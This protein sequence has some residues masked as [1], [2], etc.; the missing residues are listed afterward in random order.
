MSL[1]RDLKLWLLLVALA[2]SQA[3]ASEPDPVLPS[4]IDVNPQYAVHQPIVATVQ[5]A[6][7]IYVWDEPATFRAI[8]LDNGRVL[9]IWAP[10]GRHKLRCLLL[11]V[12][13]D[14]HTI[15]NARVTAEFVV[16]MDIPPPPPPPP[17]PPYAKL[18]G[19]FL[20]ESDTLDDEPWQA[21]IIAS[22]KIRQLQSAKLNLDWVDVDVKDEANL[23]SPDLKPWIAEIVKRKVPL[24]QVLLVSE[25]GEL[26]HV[27]AWPR[28]VDEVVKL[29]QQYM[30]K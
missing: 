30:P 25:K 12:D 15:T 7:S 22:Q 6:A 23:P 27:Q 18:W 26:I 16:G 28:T 3:A 2:V 13:W 29:L 5:T 14:K 17:P 1:L 21:N 19:M 9:H 4:R 8:E 10:P 11:T 24:P 20:Y